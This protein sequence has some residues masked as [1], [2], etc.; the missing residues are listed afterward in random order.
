[1]L[2]GMALFGIDLERA[3]L[4][5]TRLGFVVFLVFVHFLFLSLF[6]AI[7][8]HPAV[9]VRL[10]RRPVA[11]LFIL[12]ILQTMFVVFLNPD[13]RV[14]YAGNALAAFENYFWVVLLM[15]ES[16]AGARILLPY[17]HCNRK[18]N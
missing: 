9:F 3:H 2:G 8:I 12:H 16:D 18:Q 11:V 17:L 14:F 7:A 4:D 13:D 10:P 15:K 5:Y 6:T 1:M